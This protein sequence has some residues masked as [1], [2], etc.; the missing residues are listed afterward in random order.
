[1]AAPTPHSSTSYATHSPRPSEP[2]GASARL[3][4]HQQ[5][6]GEGKA[7]GAYAALG[8]GYPETVERSRRGA[9]E[10]A[11]GEPNPLPA[12]V[13]TPGAWAGTHPG[14]PGPTGQPIGKEQGGLP[15]GTPPNN[16]M[17]SP[18]DPKGTAASA[19][20]LIRSFVATRSPEGDALA[21]RA[22]LA[23]F[24]RRHQLVSEKAIPI[25]L[26]DFEEALALR[27]GL[28]ALLI[29][30]ARADS[31]TPRTGGEDGIAA[32]IA[33]GQ[34][35]LD[36]LRMTVRLAPGEAVMPL[37]P[38]VVDEVRCGLARIAAAWAVVVATGQWRR[39]RPEYAPSRGHRSGA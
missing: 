33:R 22:G 30:A 29:R 17:T 28:R 24:L 3:G 14:H 25:T 10:Q 34:R 7:K 19:V 32:A 36:G 11:A 37:T 8:F 39:I 38:A 35:V 1:M 5:E 2:V 6:E 16:A 12:T 27:D 9:P 21:D 4:A 23:S 31:L 15:E 13:R 20:A 18:T 26:S